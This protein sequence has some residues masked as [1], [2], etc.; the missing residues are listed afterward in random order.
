MGK[1][2]GGMSECA[3]NA[4]ATRASVPGEKEWRLP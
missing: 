4:L 2:S 3:D 1:S